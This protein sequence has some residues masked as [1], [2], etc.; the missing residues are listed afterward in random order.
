VLEVFQVNNERL[1]LY[2]RMNL[3]KASALTPK[4]GHKKV[5]EWI[6]EAKEAGETIEEIL[7][8]AI[9][10]ELKEQF[11]PERKAKSA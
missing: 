2:N 1:N 9:V 10:E 11:A 4:Y 5:G 6:Q 3:Q 7:P 8:S